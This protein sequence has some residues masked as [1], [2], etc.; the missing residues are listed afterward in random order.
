MNL[1]GLDTATAV[2]SACVLRADGCAFEV[3]PDPAGLLGPPGHARD[4]LPAVMRVLGESGLGWADLGGIAVGRGPGSF[5]GLRVGLAT[6]RALAQAHGLPLH[7][8]SSLA[9]LAAGAGA[10]ADAVLALIDARRGELFAAL[11]GGGELLLAPWVA[12]PAAVL[13]TV[14]GARAADE[15]PGLVAVGDGS[16]RSRELLEGSGIQVPPI[17]SPAHVVR[18]LQICRLARE[19]PASRPDRVF[20]DYLRDPDAKP[21]TR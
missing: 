17:E 20:P 18:A 21:A 2:S 14:A 11:Y 19:V 7:G 8:V 15:L 4:L 3:V 5:T 12:P 9:A 1:L 16:V 13:A 10:D 6:A